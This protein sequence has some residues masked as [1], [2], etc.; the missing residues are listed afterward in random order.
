[1]ATI[2]KIP[3]NIEKSKSY[4]GGSGGFAYQLK[5]EP[6]EATSYSVDVDYDGEAKVTKHWM[7]KGLTGRDEWQSK[8][9]MK[10]VP[11]S[12]A[13]RFVFHKLDPEHNRPPKVP[14]RSSEILKLTKRAIVE[15]DLGELLKEYGNP[16][17]AIDMA[18]MESKSVLLYE[19]QKAGVVTDSFVMLIGKDVADEILGKYIE[20]IR[21]RET[22]KNVRLGL[23]KAEAAEEADK[24][25]TSRRG[26]TFPNWKA[27][28][29]GDR[30]QSWQ[31][32]GTSVIKDTQV[33]WL[34]SNQGKF[35][36]IGIDYLD[37]IYK[38]FP[39]VD[40]ITSAKHRERSGFM[41]R[42]LD[43]D[44]H[45][46]PITFEQDGE[47]KAVM[48]PIFAESI[49]GSIRETGE[50]ITS[51]G[52]STSTAELQD[53]H[54]SRSD[55]SQSSDERQE[56]SL[57][58]EPDDPRV[59]TW[60]RDPGRMDVQGIDTPSKGGKPKKASASAIRRKTHKPDTSLGGMK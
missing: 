50:R 30:V 19:G 15:T 4:R 2:I 34:V 40:T 27:L 38:H 31:V 59:E 12:L 8:I 1:M 44:V 54:D 16:R 39:D 20:T 57:V 42:G 28:I 17:K 53:I 41:A 55:L 25:I 11:Q 48:M 24:A 26:G 35:V 43:P 14:A 7:S 36:A 22:S 21:K 52:R 60:K 3:E 58:I 51:G 37:L 49:P 33:A 6:F 9:I 46:S 23:S 29:P 5:G 10:K 47:V 18:N 32:V 45:D 13:E 56:H